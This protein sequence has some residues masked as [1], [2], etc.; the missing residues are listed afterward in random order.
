MFKLMDKKII[1]ILCSNFFIYLDYCLP[2]LL[3]SI[4]RLT[5]WWPKDELEMPMVLKISCKQPYSS[6]HLQKVFISSQEWQNLK[7]ETSLL[8]NFN[9]LYTGKFFMLLLSSADIFQK[10]LSGTPSECQTVWIQIRTNILFV[11]NWF[12]TVCQGYQQI[13]KVAV[14]KERVK[15]MHNKDNN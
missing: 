13:T 6:H 14:R 7:A 2:Y 8:I 15:C 5:N 10:I 12:Q 1:T 11:R 3:C 9:P 4:F